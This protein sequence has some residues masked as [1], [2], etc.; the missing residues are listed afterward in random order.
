MKIQSK[1]QSNGHVKPASVNEVKP[2]SVN[3]DDVSAPVFIGVL[4]G[5]S[6]ALRSC[7][8]LPFQVSGT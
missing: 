5:I 4:R 6:G 7:V 2:A 8:L 1:S 3:E